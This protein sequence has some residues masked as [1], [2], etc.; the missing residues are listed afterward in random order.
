MAPSIDESFVY[1]LAWTALGGLACVAGVVALLIAWLGR[2]SG[3]LVGGVVLGIGLAMLVGVWFATPRYWFLAIIPIAIGIQTIRQW[4]KSGE[5]RAGPWTFQLDT[6]ALAV[7]VISLFTAGAVA[8]RR[9]QQ[10][11]HQVIQEIE[12]NGGYVLE[13]FDG[14]AHTVLLRNLPRSKIDMLAPLA[15]QLR[16]VTELGLEGSQCSEPALRELAKLKRVRELSLQRAEIDPEAGKHITSFSRTVVL[17]LLKSKGL[18]AD[19]LQRLG[20]LENLQRLYL[21]QGVSP[22]VRDALRQALPEVEID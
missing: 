16:C 14:I 17:D 21:P 8:I 15:A 9:Q 20:Q 4:S 22:Q 13:S 1:L 10:F 3:M 7:V 2:P 11:E 19:D 12:G 6:F 18:A 5:E